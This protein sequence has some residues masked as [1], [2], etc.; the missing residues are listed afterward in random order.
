[1]RGELVTDRRRNGDSGQG[2]VEVA[3]DEPDP[4]AREVQEISR[5]AGS[6]DRGRRQ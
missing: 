5:P 2:D 1:M 4:A 6:A 3:V